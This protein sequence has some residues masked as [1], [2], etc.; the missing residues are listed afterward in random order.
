MKRLNLKSIG[1]LLSVLT[2][3]TFSAA[4]RADAGDNQ[5]SPAGAPVHA[6]IDT[7]WTLQLPED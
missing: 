6:S 7:G 4:G 1:W 2:S 5:P 3:L